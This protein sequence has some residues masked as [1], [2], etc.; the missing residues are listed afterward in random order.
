MNDQPTFKKVITAIAY[1]I[2][3]WKFGIGAQ[4]GQA[5]SVA[6]NIKAGVEKLDL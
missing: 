3:V 1:L 6:D 4:K 5:E 2:A